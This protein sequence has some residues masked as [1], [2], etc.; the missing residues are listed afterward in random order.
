MR[1]AA[2][3]A[4][5]FPWH[6]GERANPQQRFDNVPSQPSLLPQTKPATPNQKTAHRPHSETARACFR[7]Q[8]S[9]KFAPGRVVRDARG[10]C[11]ARQSELR[12]DHCWR[13]MHSEAIEPP[14]AAAECL[15]GQTRARTAQLASVLSRTADALEESAALADAHAERCEQAGR[16]GDAAQ[17]RRA[18]G[19]AR[20]AAR[21]A[22]SHVEEWLELAAGRKP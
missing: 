16:S 5:P 3:T 10:H 12:C 1:L 14:G 19:R 9:S 18:A 21:K 11:G 17:E 6:Y 4:R 2:L 7:G 8:T 20:E 13:A 15:I 22:R